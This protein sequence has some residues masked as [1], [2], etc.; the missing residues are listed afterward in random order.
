MGLLDFFSN[1]KSTLYFPACSL[2]KEL[3]EREMKNYIDIFKILGI[4]CFP[5]EKENIFC[6]LNVLEAG[7]RKESKKI[8]DKNFKYF[9][10]L[11]IKKI[12]TS[13]PSCF[14]MFKHIYPTLLPNWEI[15]VEHAVISIYNAIKKREITATILDKE[16]EI[17]TYHDSCHLGR[18]CGIYDEPRE[19]ITLLGSK[20]VEMKYSKK[21]S[22]CCGVSGNMIENYP[23][24]SIMIAKKAVSKIPLNR[25]LIS[26]SFYCHQNLSK[27]SENVVEFSSHVLGKLRGIENEW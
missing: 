13:C 26:P 10:K 20:V 1:Q 25:K 2:P 17:V 5:L 3:R 9:N 27:V 8:A 4:K 24:T 11:G 21:N 19:I 6:G 14:Y 15:E 22:K 18:M 16:S 23:E 7:H 12:I